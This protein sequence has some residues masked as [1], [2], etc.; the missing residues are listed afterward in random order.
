MTQAKTESSSATTTP[1][2]ALR[3]PARNRRKSKAG[4]SA[5]EAEQGRQGNWASLGNAKGSRWLPGLIQERERMFNERM[6]ALSRPPAEFR[7]CNATM[8]TDAPYR[9]GDGEVAQAVRPG[10][11]DAY[12]LKSVGGRT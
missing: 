3:R 7:V 4:A 12:A 1:G 5:A 9:T 10:S 11:M 8:P 2:P 6:R